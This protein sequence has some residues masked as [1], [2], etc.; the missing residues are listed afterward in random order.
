MALILLV[1]FGEPLSEYRPTPNSPAAAETR[2]K[3]RQTGHGAVF[4]CWHSGNLLQFVR[5]FGSFGPKGVL[6]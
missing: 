1:G 4:W 6:A 2:Q 3:I 5:F